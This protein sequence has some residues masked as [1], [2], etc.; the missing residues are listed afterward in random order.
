[1]NDSVPTGSTPRHYTAYSTGCYTL[2]TSRRTCLS[3]TH[4]LTAASSLALPATGGIGAWG[5]GDLSSL[6]YH[7]SVSSPLVAH[8]GIDGSD[9]Q[10]QI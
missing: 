6:F 9:H 1:M 8:P 2:I 4:S 3:L 10:N 7:L 5:R